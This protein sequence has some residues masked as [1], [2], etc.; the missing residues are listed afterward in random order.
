M[1]R[2]V[3]KH[4]LERAVAEVARLRFERMRGLLGDAY[5]YQS[6]DELARAVL[7]RG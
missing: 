1:S 2:S 4:G 3:D 5:P 7:E 6:A